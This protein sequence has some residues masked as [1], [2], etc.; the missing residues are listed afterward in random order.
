MFGGVSASKYCF[1]QRARVT[2]SISLFG[3][4][5]FGKTELRKNVP[6]TY[7]TLRKEVSLRHYLS[8][9]AGLILTSL[10][11]PGAPRQ[12]IPVRRPN[13]WR[14][15]H[16]LTRRSNICRPSP[17][18]RQTPKS[19]Q[20]TEFLKF[21]RTSP[22]SCK[23]GRFAALS[24]VDHA[25]GKVAGY[26]NGS[27][28]RRELVGLVYSNSQGSAHMPQRDLSAWSQGFA[29]CLL[30]SMVNAMCI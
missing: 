5:T 13:S 12:L 19:D 18:G 25:N 30:E 11:H 17:R 3:M 6:Q 24:S 23:Q 20:N 29:A 1:R 21:R 10:V 27:P 15:S 26:G 7:K 22:S 2:H 4:W 16:S 28:G 8:G 14:R 9:L